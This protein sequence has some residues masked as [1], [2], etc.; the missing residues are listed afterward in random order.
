MCAR[1]H[2]ESYGLQ[3]LQ[4]GVWESIHRGAVEAHALLNLD[5]PIRSDS[6]W[7]C[8]AQFL[9]ASSAST[10]ATTV[11]AM[12]GPSYVPRHVFCWTLFWLPLFTVCRQPDWPMPKYHQRQRRRHLWLLLF[13]IKLG[14]CGRNMVSTIRCTCFRLVSRI[15]CRILW[16]LCPITSTIAAEASTPPATAANP[17]PTAA[18]GRVRQHMPI[19]V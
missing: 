14:V 17:T 4:H 2:E 10:F 3:Q 15:M 13:G 11:L 12:P 19:C 1:E 9:L 5:I 7:Q 16:C 18:P 8:S 6:Q